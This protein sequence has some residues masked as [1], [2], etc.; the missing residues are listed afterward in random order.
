MRDDFGW[1]VLGLQWQ[2]SI[3]YGRLIF[4]EDSIVA[5]NQAGDVPIVTPTPKRLNQPDQCRFPFSNNAEICAAQFEQFLRQYAETTAAQ[6]HG[7]A[8]LLMHHS[9]QHP[10]F[11]DE[12][13]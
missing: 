9:D 11:L 6:H 5:E 2:L 8:A 7:T 10:K 1:P 4:L 3:V 12:S 13:L